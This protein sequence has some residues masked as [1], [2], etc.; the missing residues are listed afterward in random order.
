MQTTEDFRNKREVDGVI[1][2]ID[3]S[4]IPISTPITNGA[5]YVN[6]EGFHTLCHPASSLHE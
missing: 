3:G 2:A 4:H 1:G 6:R 5:G